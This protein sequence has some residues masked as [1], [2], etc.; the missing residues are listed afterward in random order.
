MWQRAPKHL[1]TLVIEANRGA[2]TLI[3]SM[4]LASKVVERRVGKEDRVSSRLLR[5]VIVNE[6]VMDLQI[7][8]V[9]IRDVR[10]RQRQPSQLKSKRIEITAMQTASQV[11]SAMAWDLLPGWQHL[12][13]QSHR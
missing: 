6:H 7:P 2:P 13:E 5:Q 4:L 9:R 3:I 10:E 12:R 8:V 11:R 1:G